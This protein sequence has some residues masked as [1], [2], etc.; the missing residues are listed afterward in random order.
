M[1]VI[2]NVDLSSQSLRFCLTSLTGNGQRVVRCQ[3]GR[4]TCGAQRTT[5][6]LHGIPGCKATHL[7]A[8]R[9]LCVGTCSIGYVGFLRPLCQLLRVDKC[10]GL[11]RG[12]TR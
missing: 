2:P 9:A 12:S 8:P 11:G 1:F 4:I 5:A 7:Y 10:N 6:R 3:F